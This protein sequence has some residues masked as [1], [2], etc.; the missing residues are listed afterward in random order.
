M[1]GAALIAAALSG[2]EAGP[3]IITVANVDTDWHTSNAG[4]TL[5]FVTATDIPVG[6]QIFSALSTG[7]DTL[8]SVSYGGNN[9]TISVQGSGHAMGFFD[10]TSV[11]PSGTTIT[12]TWSSTSGRKYAELRATTGLASG[13]PTSVGTVTA[14]V[15]STPGFSA[16]VADANSLVAA[17][18]YLSTDAA[19]DAYVESAGF[20]SGH[21]VPGDTRILRTAHAVAAS[22]GTTVYSATNGDPTPV[23]RS[24]T[25]NH[26]V[27]KGA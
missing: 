12:L 18:I 13:A 2:G 11:I 20:T 23:A 21:N 3:S 14:G 15:T 26:L 27:F 4:A 6:K 5:T 19:T 16:T 9:F 24:W 10:N 17:G 1:M 22:A 25:L 8:S 7:G